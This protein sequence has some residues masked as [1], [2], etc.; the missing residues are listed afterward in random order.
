MDRTRSVNDTQEI[1]VPSRLL[2]ERYGQPTEEGLPRKITITHDRRT[3][4]LIR[5]SNGKLILN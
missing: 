5:T 3:Y 1:G 2:F 4:Q